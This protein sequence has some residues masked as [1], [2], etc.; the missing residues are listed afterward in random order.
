MR[1]K[2]LLS[3]IDAIA[4]FEYAEPWDNV[5]LQVGDPEAPV[6]RV[7]CA[8]EPST[9]SIDEARRLGCECLI[10]HH[11]LF[12][13]GLRSLRVGEYPQ[14]HIFELFRRDINLIV[15][16][17]NL[18]V[19]KN[20]G[21]KHIADLLTLQ[22]VEPIESNQ[23][24]SMRE[25]YVGM[26]LLGRLRSSCSLMELSERIVSYL[27]AEGA[28]L[29]GDPYKPIQTVAICTGS[30]SSLIKKVI[31]KGIDCFITGEIKY[32]DAVWAKEARLSLILL[33]HFTSEKFMMA[34]FSKRLKALSSG[35]S[36]E[37]LWFE[38][39]RDPSLF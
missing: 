7:L 8:L 11:P 24:F 36:L 37:V 33:G 2:D 20:G 21:N 23:R 4:P 17:T 29:I 32:H 3:W 9:S 34:E 27:R 39:E 35:T 26:G 15:A 38:Q 5:G 25:T 18:D 30:G 1:V 12:L 16:H 22:N 10:V 14:N 19:S 31:S 6:S 28:N 13:E